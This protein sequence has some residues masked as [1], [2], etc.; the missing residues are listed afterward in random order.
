MR[1][2]FT[3]LTVL[4]VEEHFSPEI[5]TCF[6]VVL[7]SICENDHEGFTWVIKQNRYWS[8]NC[9]VF[10]SAASSYVVDIKVIPS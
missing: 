8:Y 9:T 3:P 6:C 1:I 2:T 5:W 7:K 4:V 10:R